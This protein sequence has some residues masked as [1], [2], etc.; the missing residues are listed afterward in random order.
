MQRYRQDMW[1]NRNFMEMKNHDMRNTDSR[2][3]RAKNICDK[4]RPAAR[5]IGESSELLAAAECRGD[6][7]SN[8]CY[9]HTLRAAME[10]PSWKRPFR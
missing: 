5:L 10:K 3:R 2:L 8:E 7:I 1:M 6:F 4:G 9:T